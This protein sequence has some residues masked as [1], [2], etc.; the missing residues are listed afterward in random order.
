V[1]N[2]RALRHELETAFAR[3]TVDR[4]IGRLEEFGVACGRVRTV[5]E[6]LADPQVDA[7]QMLLPLD[8]IELAG[9]QVLG[10]PIKLSN[11]P[12][13]LYRRPPKLGEHTDEVL[14]GA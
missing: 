11:A 10:N 4:L 14:K 12:A 1:A 13:R 2:R 6:A 8:D 7:R 9:F 5:P 3:F